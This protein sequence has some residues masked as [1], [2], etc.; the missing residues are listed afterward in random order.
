[1]NGDFIDI[2]S[3][4]D[5]YNQQISQLSGGQLQRVLLTAGSIT[6]PDL[7]I[8]H[9]PTQGLDI[10]NQYSFYSMLNEIKKIST[11]S[12]LLISHD[13]HNVL[14][15]SDQILCLNKHLCCSTS[16]T[17]HDMDLYKKYLKIYEHHHDHKHHS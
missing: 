6:S 2:M 14:K 9:E 3:I 4:Q 5:F 11:T 7:S 1:M 12:I 13:L 8:L 17:I 15:K 10:E 16:G